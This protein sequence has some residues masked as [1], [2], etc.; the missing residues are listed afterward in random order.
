MVK[1]NCR[2]IRNLFLLQRI[3]GS[4][5]P[6][7]LEGV[8]QAIPEGIA[9]ATAGR[10]RPVSFF[11]LFRRLTSKDGL[12]GLAEAVNFL[13]GLWTPAAFGAEL[14]SAR[15]D[16]HWNPRS[17]IQLA[18]MLNVEDK[19]RSIPSKDPLLRCVPLHRQARIPRP[20]LRTP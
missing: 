11:S 6:E 18:Q 17:D 9:Q 1:A 4:I 5:Q 8:A 3:L 14:G 2:P 13:Q 10:D 15:L 16:N 20:Y 12:R 7:W 19:T